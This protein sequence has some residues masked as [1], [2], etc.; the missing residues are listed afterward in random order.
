MQKRQKSNIAPYNFAMVYAGLGDK[1]KAIEQL[2]KD[3]QSGD[4]TFKYLAVDPYF[5]IYIRTLVSP[6]SAPCRI[7]G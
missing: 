3:H 7:S 6:T 1:D 4:P 2:E 5:K